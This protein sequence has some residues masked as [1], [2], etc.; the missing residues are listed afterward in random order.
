MGE[1]R[2]ATCLLCCGQEDTI[3]KLFFLREKC[4][5]KEYIVETKNRSFLRIVQKQVSKCQT[6][7]SFFDQ[8]FL[9][10]QTGWTIKMLIMLNQL[11]Y[12]ILSSKTFKKF[13]VTAYFIDF[14]KR[15]KQAKQIILDSVSLQ[16]HFILRNKHLINKPFKMTIVYYSILL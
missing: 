15:H 12:I 3:K 1:K 6:N 9:F 14:K 11:L 16:K 7:Y 10:N 4:L 2:H 13:T 8:P 5:F